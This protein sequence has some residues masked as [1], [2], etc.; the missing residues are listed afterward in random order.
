MPAACSPSFDTVRAP[1]QDQFF[2]GSKLHLDR[3]F[4]SATCPRPSNE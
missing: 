1:A 3:V 2:A 4:P